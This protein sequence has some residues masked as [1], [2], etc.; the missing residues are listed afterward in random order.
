MAFIMTLGLDTV[1]TFTMISMNVGWTDLFLQKFLQ[2][3][4]IGFA[5]AFPTSVVAIFFARKFVS[6][7]VSD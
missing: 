2:G 7:L 4:L 1:M 3:W 6:S 5:V